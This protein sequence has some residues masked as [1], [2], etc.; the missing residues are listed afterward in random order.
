MVANDLHKTGKWGTITPANKNLI[1]L[2]SGQIGSCMYFE[3]LN[4]NNL[5][6]VG[7]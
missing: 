6:Y 1:F 7:S 5:G 2:K 3:V 4:G